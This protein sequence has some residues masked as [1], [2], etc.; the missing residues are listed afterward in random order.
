MDLLLCFQVG[1]VSWWYSLGLRYQNNFKIKGLLCLSCR[2]KVQ[3]CFSHF[4]PAGNGSHWDGREGALGLGQPWAFLVTPQLPWSRAAHEL[5]LPVPL[6]HPHHPSIWLF[7]SDLVS[8]WH[9][10]AVILPPTHY[11]QGKPCLQSNCR[12]QC[13][14]FL[15]R[16]T[17]WLQQVSSMLHGSGHAQQIKNQPAMQETGDAGSIP[18]SGRSPGGGKWKPTPVSLPEKSHWQRSLVSYSPEGGKESGTTEWLSTHIHALS[19]SI[20]PVHSQTLQPM[21]YLN[22]TKKGGLWKDALTPRRE[23]ESLSLPRTNLP[24]RTHGTGWSPRA[25]LCSLLTYPTCSLATL[26][27]SYTQFSP[28]HYQPLWKQT[29]LHPLCILPPHSTKY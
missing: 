18:G 1:L 5:G 15:G 14:C 19:A 6:V 11:I 12:L 4:H 21:C 2:G 10:K 13:S 7:H 22:P 3:L 26:M 20:R 8:M 23:S 29:T 27:I 24:T 25:L 9:S 28:F 16:S 17:L